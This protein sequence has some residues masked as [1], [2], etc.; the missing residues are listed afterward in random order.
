MVSLSGE[1]RVEVEIKLIFSAASSS[2]LT[3]SHVI[4]ARLNDLDRDNHCECRKIAVLNFILGDPETNIC[5][6]AVCMITL[7][8]TPK[9]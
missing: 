1:R 5:K 6:L 4:K 8:E 2:E 3:S 7:Q 9:L